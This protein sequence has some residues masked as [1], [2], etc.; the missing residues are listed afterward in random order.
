MS[1]IR[2]LC[3]KDICPLLSSNPEPR[4][5]TGGTSSKP[6][7]KDRPLPYSSAATSASSLS[8]SR[9]SW[10]SNGYMLDQPGHERTPKEL[11][12]EG[13]SVFESLE[14][15]GEEEVMRSLDP[16]D[17]NWPLKVCCALQTFVTAG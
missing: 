8:S 13:A 12:I 17:A 10:P 7:K 14:R 2:E 9:A 15:E 11:A 1:I 16:D 3:R 6:H 5:S 4:Y